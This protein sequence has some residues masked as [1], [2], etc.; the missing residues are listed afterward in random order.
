M[1]IVYENS[2]FGT[3]SALRMMWFCRENDIVIKS[4]QP[5][6]KKGA[7]PEYLR[8]LLVPIQKNVP[9]VLFLVSYLD[10]AV[11]L[12]DA[13]SALNINALL[14]GGAGG[15]THED[16]SR[17]TGNTSEYLLTATLW[18]PSPQDRLADDFSQRYT[19]RASHK[20]DYHAAEAYSA[21]LVAAEAL[22]NSASMKPADIRTALDAI[23]METPFGRVLFTAYD[24]Y[25]RQNIS[26]T[27]VLQVINGRFET[28][29][30]KN[31]ATADYVLPA[32]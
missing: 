17:R 29:W 5:Y 2:P 28:V 11:M 1:S 27:Q 9:E 13:I 23:D 12:I 8:R 32:R 3:G 10:D 20:P 14:C 15:F 31:K 16:F 21:L 26:E 18:S 4:I 24:S 19:K 6:F 25:R 7:T 30:P 22:R